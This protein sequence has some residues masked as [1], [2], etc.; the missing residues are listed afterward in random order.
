MDKAIATDIDLALVA[1]RLLVGFSAV[2]SAFQVAVMSVRRS[3][4][5]QLI[6]AGNT[7]A[8]RAEPLVEQ[9]DAFLTVSRL[10]LAASYTAAVVLTAAIAVAVASL[11][12]RPAESGLARE[13]IGRALLSL[14]PALLAG[15]VVG[16]LCFYLF[17]DLLPRTY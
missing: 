5:T 8:R 6:E 2:I 10:A 3:R 1:Y 14:L 4:L 12:A 11:S 9:P 16:S 13:A 17:G 7:A 15:S